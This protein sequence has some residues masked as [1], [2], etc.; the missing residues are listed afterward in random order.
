[1]LQIENVLVSFDLL[2]KKFC[3]DLK[4]CKGVCCIEGDYGAPLEKTEIEEI[5]RNF[6]QIRE[7]MTLAGIRSVEEQGFAVKDREGE[8][9]TPLV[10]G[11]ECAYAI[12]SD[13]ICLCAIEKAWV[14]KKSDFR[15]PESCH[16]YPLRITRYPAFEAVNYH[17][18]KICREA[19]VKGEKEG[20]PLYRFLKEPLIAKYGKEWYE[21]LE[22][23]AREYEAGRL[24]V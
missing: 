13:G 9:T 1:M 19:V 20:I 22:Y 24:I 23:A 3:C 18:W 6:G 15:K 2:E 14:Q 17:K 10:S 8:W 21:Q 12:Q 5:R 16:L 7:Y 11:R 4:T